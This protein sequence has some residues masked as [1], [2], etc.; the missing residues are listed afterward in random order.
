[1]NL[2]C[3]LLAITCS[4]AFIGSSAQVKTF[5]F[6]KSEPPFSRHAY[7]SSL[8]ID[9]R[10]NKRNIGLVQRGI[11]NT[12]SALMIDPTLEEALQNHLNALLANGSGTKEI[13][14]HIRQFSFAELT[15]TFSEEGF[16]R[17]RAEA[18]EQRGN[19]FLPLLKIDTL[20]T[21][22]GLDVTNKILK[23]GQKTIYEWVEAA[24][25]EYPADV[26]SLTK[27][28]IFDID[29]IEKQNIPLYNSSIFPTGIYHT[30]QD[31]ANLQP[32]DTLVNFQYDENLGRIKAYR[33]DV[34]G[35][36]TEVVR[37]T[38]KTGYA[39]SFNNRLWILV[40]AGYSPVDFKE[41]SF[42]FY[43]PYSAASINTAKINSYIFFGLIGGLIY[44][45]A[46]P[47]DKLSLHMVDHLNGGHIPVK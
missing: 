12:I 9:G 40:P 42:Y 6:K 47:E 36:Q 28:Q 14:I 18:Y 45:M 4:C 21:V 16:F 20:V 5:R 34:N 38:D 37:L 11:T 7:Q 10:K 41:G 17:I 31:L 35:K 33:T 26:Q 39:V 15:R 8:V 22:S 27:E 29:R 2:K 30:F 44:T 1:M 25:K 32:N 19:S 3:I 13:M 46:N 24:L 23:E 43:A